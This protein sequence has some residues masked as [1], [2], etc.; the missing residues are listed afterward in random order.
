MRLSA[1]I[2]PA[3]MAVTGIA[4]TTVS[5]SPDVP[6]SH[7]SE[8]DIEQGRAIETRDVPSILKHLTKYQ[9]TTFG[10]RACVVGALADE[11]GLYQSP[12]VYVTSASTDRVDWMRRLPYPAEFYQSRA[13]HCLAHGDYVYVLLQVDTDS[14]QATNQTIVSVVKLDARSGRLVT[15]REVAIDGVG[16]G[17]SRWLNR[18]E[19]VFQVEGNSIRVSGRYRNMDSDEIEAFS[20]TVD[21]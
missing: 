8:R 2:A 19:D 11:D 10:K 13:T 12:Y 5:A 18:S 7:P 21:L 4:I 1:K 15:A 9:S 6:N 14:H 16:R 17:A 3:L 20:T